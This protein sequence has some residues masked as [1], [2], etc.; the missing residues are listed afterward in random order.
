MQKNIQVKC[1]KDVIMKD[2]N[3]KAFTKGKFYDAVQEGEQIIATNDD[4]YDNHYIND[5]NLTETGWF[6]KHFV[7]VFEE[8]ESLPEN[9]R[10]LLEEEKKFMEGHIPNIE[11]T[12]ENRK[13]GLLEDEARLA[14]AKEDLANIIKVLE[15]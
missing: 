12:I 9:V 11:K 15:G 1:I 2:D 13:I 14:K 6:D 3:T 5:K 10:K 7:V 4:E 8:K